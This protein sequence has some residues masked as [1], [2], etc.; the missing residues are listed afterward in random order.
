MKITKVIKY[1]LEPAAD[2]AA[3]GIP[4]PFVSVEFI[5]HPKGMPGFT[6]RVAYNSVLTR[7]Y[8]GDNAKPN[9]AAALFFAN[10]LAGEAQ[11]FLA[12]IDTPEG[13]KG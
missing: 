8:L 9:R 10:K 2:E 3:L 13:L 6:H 1:I 7:S 5:P 4:G 11:P 12:E